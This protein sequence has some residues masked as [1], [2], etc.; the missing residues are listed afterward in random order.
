MDSRDRDL[1]R[2]FAWMDAEGVQ[3]RTAVVELEL[4]NQDIMTLRAGGPGINSR[5]SGVSYETYEVLL[6][7]DPARFW[8]RYTDSAGVLY[9]HVPRL[10]LYHH[11]TRRGGVEKQ[12]RRTETREAVNELTVRLAVPKERETEVLT[13][14]AS[15]TG[16]N[17]I[18]S[19]RKSRYDLQVGV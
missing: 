15:L 9:A 7:H 3:G 4:H 2:M 11:I 16:V 18:N 5:S 10:L 6:D 1:L 12:A 14:I 17:L 13:T 8:Q 19:A